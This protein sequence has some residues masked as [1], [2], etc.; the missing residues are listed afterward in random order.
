MFPSR[1]RGWAIEEHSSPGGV[2]FARDRGRPRPFL[3]EK[4]HLVGQNE[5]RRHPLP[6]RPQYAHIREKFG[7]E[8]RGSDLTR[9]IYMWE[10]GNIQ[11]GNHISQELELRLLKCLVT[12]VVRLLAARSNV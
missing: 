4:M 8:L 9:R 10:D 3:I 5:E 7:I 2:F 6:H 11:T 1:T 12:R